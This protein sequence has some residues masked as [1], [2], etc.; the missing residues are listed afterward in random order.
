VAVTVATYVPLTVIITERRG[1]V[2]KVMNALDNAREARATDMLLNYEVCACH[3]VQSTTRGVVVVVTGAGMHSHL[4][5][6]SAR[7][8]M[9]RTKPATRLTHVDC[10]LSACTRGVGG[11]VCFKASN[12]WRSAVGI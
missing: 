12:S 8:S 10:L 5:G 9:H 11:W 3:A 2:R 7:S 4:L 1:A 6:L